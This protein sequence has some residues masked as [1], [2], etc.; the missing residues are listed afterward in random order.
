M[1][2]VRV[3]DRYETCLYSF[4]VAILSHNRS[5]SVRPLIGLGN[6]QPKPVAWDVLRAALWPEAA[7]YLLR[8]CGWRPTSLPDGLGKLITTLTTAWSLLLLPSS[9]AAAVTSPRLV[10]ACCVRC[11]GLSVDMATVGLSAFNQRQSAC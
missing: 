3:N 10:R 4:I 9:A 2:P 11:C 5:L 8:A 7:V 6:N 1:P